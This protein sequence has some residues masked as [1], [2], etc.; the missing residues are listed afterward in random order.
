[1]VLVEVNVHVLWKQLT[2]INVEVALLCG[3]E[4][5]EEWSLLFCWLE[6]QSNYR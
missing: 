6:Q 3:V 1:M 5:L 2:K 4:A